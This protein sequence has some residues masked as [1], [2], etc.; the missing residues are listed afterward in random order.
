M[1]PAHEGLDV[2]DLPRAH[3]DLRLVGEKELAGLDPAAQLFESTRWRLW[4]ASSP[5]E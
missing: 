5:G 2:R 3:V 4:N 1:A